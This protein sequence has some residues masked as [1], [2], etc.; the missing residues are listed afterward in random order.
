MQGV[1]VSGMLGE[2]VKCSPSLNGIQKNE[3]KI[4]SR[5]G[6]TIIDM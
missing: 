5:L 6:V 3:K 1:D 2:Y 4:N